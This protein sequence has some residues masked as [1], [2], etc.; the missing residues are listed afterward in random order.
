M[1]DTET[2][3]SLSAKEAR[4]I[5]AVIRTSKDYTGWNDSKLNEFMG[6]ITI[7]EMNKLFYKLDKKYNP[8]NYIERW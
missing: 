6:S 2:R 7:D 4:T 5:L 8:D 1:E 3:V